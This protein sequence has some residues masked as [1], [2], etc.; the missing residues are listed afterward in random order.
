[1]IVHRK[2]QP[3]ACCLAGSHWHW[4]QESNAFWTEVGLERGY[5]AL[6]G[7]NFLNQGVQAIQR[8]LVPDDLRR[9]RR[10]PIPSSIRYE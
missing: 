10:R 6:Q 4:L 1:H 5:S 2:W 9:P 7:R 8:L 3:K